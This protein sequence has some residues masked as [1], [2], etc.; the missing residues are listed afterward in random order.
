MIIL[1]NENGE[2][3]DYDKHG[4]KGINISIPSPSYETT[5]ATVHG[6]YGSIPLERKLQPRPIAI[7]FLLRANDLDDSYLLRDDLF[8]LVG[9]E[10]YLYVS[11]KRQPYKRWKVYMQDSGAEVERHG[12]RMLSAVFPFIAPLGLA[13]SIGT[14]LSPLRY[15]ADTWQYGQG[16]TYDDKKYIH[17]TRHFNIYNAGDVTIDPRKLPLLIKLHFFF[18]EP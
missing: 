6:G 9:Q 12:L 13:E 14:T 15:D 5:F 18:C 8:R 1:R 16:L 2:G 4:I 10:G 3:I 11:E 17:D 7:R